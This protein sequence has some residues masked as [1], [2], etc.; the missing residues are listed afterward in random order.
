MFSKKQQSF[1]RDITDPAALALCQKGIA[2]ISD[3]GHSKS[4]PFLIDDDI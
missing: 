3:M 2:E 1:V 4:M